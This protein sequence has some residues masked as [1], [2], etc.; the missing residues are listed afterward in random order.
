MIGLGTIVNA[1][2]IILGGL[3][4]L[5]SRRFLKERY[6]ETITVAMGFA[7]IVMALGSAMSRMLVVEISEI[8]GRHKRQP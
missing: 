2:A 1:A 4:G 7:I 3:A 5:V 8:S 6:Q